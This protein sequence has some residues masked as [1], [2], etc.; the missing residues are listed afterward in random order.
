MI[1]RPCDQD[2]TVFHWKNGFLNFR[3]NFIHYISLQR[4]KRVNYGTSTGDSLLLLRKFQ[5]G[6]WKNLRPELHLCWNIAGDYLE[7]CVWFAF[8]LPEWTLCPAHAC[9]YPLIEIIWGSLLWLENKP[10]L[11]LAQFFGMHALLS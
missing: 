4:L 8:G 5:V 7:S 3:N 10:S 6:A 2:V 1:R 9:Q 11:L